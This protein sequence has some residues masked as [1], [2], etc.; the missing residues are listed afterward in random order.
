MMTTQ[1]PI[2]QRNLHLLCM[3]WAKEATVV[4]DHSFTIRDAD[5]Q[6]LCTTARPVATRFSI[7][8]SAFMSAWIQNQASFENEPPEIAMVYS[9]MPAGPD[10]IAH[11]IPV[12]LTKPS[13]EGTDAWKFEFAP[14]NPALPAGT[15]RDIT[16]FIDW[17]PS[18]HCPE[19]ISITFPKLFSYG[20]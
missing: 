17:L 1:A 6:V 3:I 10:G 9:R 16:L 11:A 12:V 8:T 18:L 13:A 19:P 20:E 7:L 5:P 2:K 4:G 14:P 15:F